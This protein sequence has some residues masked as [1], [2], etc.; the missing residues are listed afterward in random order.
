[1]DSL[2]KR[3]QAHLARYPFVK[4]QM[5]GGLLVELLKELEKADILYRQ[6][7]GRGLRILPLTKPVILDYCNNIPRSPVLR[8]M[9]LEGEFTPVPKPATLSVSDQVPEPDTVEGYR[10]LKFEEVG[11]KPGSRKLCNCTNA[12]QC[13]DNSNAHDEWCRVDF[14]NGIF[15]QVE[16]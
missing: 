15:K 8:K 7:V 12:E 11:A 16:E 3:I 13:W 6:R 14:N 9:W 1:M 5:T 4:K 2:I 10:K